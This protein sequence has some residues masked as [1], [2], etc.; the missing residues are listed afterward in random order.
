MPLYD[1]KCRLCN[2]VFESKEPVGAKLAT[3]PRC[4]KALADRHGFPL[5]APHAWGCSS[6]G[7]MPKGSG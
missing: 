1:F 5:S 2:A 4:E 3:C 6:D 7:A